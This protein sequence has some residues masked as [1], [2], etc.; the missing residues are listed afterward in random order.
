MNIF[1]L[2]SSNLWT[3]HMNEQVQHMCDRHIVKM[4]AESVQMLVTVLPDFPETRTMSGDLP[5]KPLSANM[6]KHP[7]TRWTAQRAHNFNYLAHLALAMCTE[8]QHRYPLSP[9]HAYMQWLRDLCMHLYNQGLGL[10]TATVPT[11][12]AVAVKDPA[13]RHT[14]RPHHEVVVLYRDYYVRDKHK[15]ATW[16]R[17]AK[18]LWFMMAEEELI[19]QGKL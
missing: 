2:S 5:C 9:Q 15:F 16:K 18:P 13:L 4:I 8:H 19:A 11:H 10:H 12:F 1:I 17:R 14:A 3:Q 6:A 7:C